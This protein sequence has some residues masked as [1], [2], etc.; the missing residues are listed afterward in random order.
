M[1]HYEC[2]VLIQTMFDNNEKIHDKK[3]ETQKWVL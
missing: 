2:Y 1:E 3:G